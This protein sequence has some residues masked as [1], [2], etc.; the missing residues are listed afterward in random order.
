MNPNNP[1]RLM[2]A[3]T[4]LRLALPKILLQLFIYNLTEYL[5]TKQPENN[6]Y[7][8]F[9][10][11]NADQT[12]ILRELA[13]T[14]NNNPNTMYGMVE[15][16]AI[17]ACLLDSSTE[18][19][20]DPSIINKYS[21]SETCLVPAALSDLEHCQ[22]YT[23]EALLPTFT[24]FLKYQHLNNEQLEAAFEA[25]VEAKNRTEE[26]RNNPMKFEL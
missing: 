25:E 23:R 22:E 26:K 16:T 18:L 10:D 11:A 24:T 19:S 6:V 20:N 4:F 13:H 1:N 21:L 7:G 15:D 14:S 9:F 17:N 3:L 2:I 8:L 12:A 5:T